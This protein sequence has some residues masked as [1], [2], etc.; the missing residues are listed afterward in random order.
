MTRFFIIISLISF[1]IGCKQSHNTIHS[2]SETEI[3]AIYPDPINLPFGFVLGTRAEQITKKRYTPKSKYEIARYCPP[4]SS[5]NYPYATVIKNLARENI[6][7]FDSRLSKIDF[8]AL[9][10]P[11]GRKEFLI[12]PSFRSSGFRLYS[13][14]MH[15]NQDVFAAK[16]IINSSE[17]K[18][19]MDEYDSRRLPPSVERIIYRVD[20]GFAC[21]EFINNSLRQLTINGYSMSGGRRWGSSERFASILAAVESKYSEYS[22][23]IYYQEEYCGSFTGL[24]DIGDDPSCIVK[25]N[26]LTNSEGIAVTYLLKSKDKIGSSILEMKR[27]AWREWEKNGYVQ[28]SDQSFKDELKL[29]YSKDSEEFKSYYSPLLQAVYQKAVDHYGTQNNYLDQF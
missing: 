5:F 8:D 28:Y 12:N 18:T 2:L 16:A 26:V 20:G 13:G 27:N 15:Y 22:T 1:N 17:F 29:I 19:A 4:P 21:A 23:E 14:S 24:A 11:E 7:A 6:K 10:S 9:S 3:T 25:K